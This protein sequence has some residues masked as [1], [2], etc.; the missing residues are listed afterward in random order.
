MPDDRV[1]ATVQLR[2]AKELNALLE[3]LPERIHKRITRKAMKKAGEP[4]LQETLL[5]APR[6]SEENRSEPS[7]KYGHLIDN[8]T[9]GKVHLRIAQGHANIQIG[10]GDAFWGLFLQKGVHGVRGKPGQ[11]FPMPPNRFFEDAFEATW[12]E[13]RDI[14]WREIWS[15][16]AK[17]K[18]GV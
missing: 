17:Q 12:K 3:H 7:H 5:R 11:G 15:F 16:I 9:L 13:A 4:V 18:T 14:M 2:G 8:I 6:S 1:K 10:T